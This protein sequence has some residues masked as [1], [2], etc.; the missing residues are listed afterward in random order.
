MIDVNSGSEC[1]E[2]LSVLL[3]EQSLFQTQLAQAVALVSSS[4]SW[5][6]EVVTKV[7]EK[8]VHG[9]EASFA[10]RTEFLLAAT[11]QNLRRM[12]KWLFPVGP[13]TANMA[14]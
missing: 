6:H 11:A 7:W 9:A 8:A 10:E 5:L 13:E 3:R 14:I 12:A 2:I 1:H 4:R